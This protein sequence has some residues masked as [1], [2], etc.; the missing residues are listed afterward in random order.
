MEQSPTFTAGDVCRALDVPRG[1]LNSWAHHGWFE[2]FDSQETTPRKARQFT[3]PDLIRLAIIRTLTGQGID[4][5]LAWPLM[6]QTIRLISRPGGE[7]ITE[8][9]LLVFED[10][11]TEFRTD[12][13]LMATQPQVAPIMRLTIYPRAIVNALKRRLDA[14]EALAA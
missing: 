4:S 1:T 2:G 13:A 7:A 8:V 11:S 10:G 9:S 14:G 5:H 3:L 6:D 12:E